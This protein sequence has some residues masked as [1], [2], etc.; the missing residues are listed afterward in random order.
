MTGDVLMI[1]DLSPC[2][3]CEA[4]TERPYYREYGKTVVTCSSKCKTRLREILRAND[5]RKQGMDL[6]AR[7]ETSGMRWTG[8][9]DV[10]AGLAL[11]RKGSCSVVFPAALERALRD[12][13]IHG[14]RLARDQVDAEIMKPQPRKAAHAIDDL[15]ERLDKLDIIYD[16]TNS[17][18]VL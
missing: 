9:K 2:D 4:A 18:K 1:D 11:D 3:L 16:D 10:A 12:A 15:V 17:W 13:I 6:R 8:I 7:N 14:A 5:L